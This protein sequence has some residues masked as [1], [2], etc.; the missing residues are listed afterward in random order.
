MF[1]AEG[2]SRLGPSEWDDRRDPAIL[3]RIKLLVVATILLTMT[4]IPEAGAASSWYT[5]H[6]SY[7]HGSWSTIFVRSFQ[8]AGLHFHHYNHYQNIPWTYLHHTD[9]FIS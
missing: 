6:G 1:L 5:G 2:S 7:D 9:K 4:A 8:D 3:R